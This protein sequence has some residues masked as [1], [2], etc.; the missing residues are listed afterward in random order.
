[1]PKQVKNEYV[2]HSIN[3]LKRWKE[4]L[5]VAGSKMIGQKYE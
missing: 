2:A 5:V 4:G 1:L 3:T